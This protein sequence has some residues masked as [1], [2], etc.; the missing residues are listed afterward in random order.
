MVYEKTKGIP[1]GEWG[2]AMN[3]DALCTEVL[4]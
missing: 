1:G 4:Y 3:Y 2:I